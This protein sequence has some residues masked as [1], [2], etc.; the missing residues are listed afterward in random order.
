MWTGD[1]LGQ[2]SEERL[3]DE[4]KLSRLDDVQDLLYL[5]QE[6]HLGTGEGGR[7]GGR[8]EGKREGGREKD[9]ENET[10]PFLW[11]MH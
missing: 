7:E 10:I 5:S 8:E 6:H 9:K 4:D 1:T 3:L 11:M 2:L